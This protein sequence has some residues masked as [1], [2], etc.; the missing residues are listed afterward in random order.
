MVIGIAEIVILT[1]KRKERKKI[2]KDV[3]KVLTK[4]KICGNINKLSL[5]KLVPNNAGITKQHV[6]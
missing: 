1:E 4:E 6:H 5:M 3:K 2:K